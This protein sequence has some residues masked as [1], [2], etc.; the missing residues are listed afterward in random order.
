MYLLG[1]KQ[2]EPHKP[3]DL[4]LHSQHLF[5]ILKLRSKAHEVMGPWA[6]ALFKSKH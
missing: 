4:D 5:L 6:G 3:S 2:L 1:I